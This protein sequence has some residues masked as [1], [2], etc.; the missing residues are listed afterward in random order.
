[1]HASCLRGTR[2]LRSA[3]SP[4]NAGRV[5]L[6]SAIQPCIPGSHYGLVKKHRDIEDDSGQTAMTCGQLVSMVLISDELA[7]PG[8]PPEGSEEGLHASGS[9]N[10]LL[11]SVSSADHPPLTAVP[12]PVMPGE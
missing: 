2:T 3:G 11:R 12:R 8:V 10:G 4:D 7:L 5:S 1:M 9:L 6:P